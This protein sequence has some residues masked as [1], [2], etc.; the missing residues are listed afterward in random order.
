VDER[1]GAGNRS[2][3]VAVGSEVHHCIDLVLPQE[4]IH[5]LSVTDVPLHKRVTFGIGQAL[6]VVK[7]SSISKQ[8]EINYLDALVGFQQV[9]DEV[10]TNESCPAGY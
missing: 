9:S 4:T 6:E 1:C 5:Q 2:V 8:I 3:Y 10:A 7:R